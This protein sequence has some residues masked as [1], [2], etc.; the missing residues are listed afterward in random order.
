[1]VV[2]VEAE[3]VAD[4]VDGLDPWAWVLGVTVEVVEEPAASEDEGED[5]PEP[6]TKY[7]FKMGR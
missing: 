7:F 6:L 4:T 1:M 5:E 3:E 2:A